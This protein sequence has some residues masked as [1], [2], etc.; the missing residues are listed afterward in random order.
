MDVWVDK[1]VAASDELVFTAGTHRDAIRMRYSDFAALVN[2]RV[3]QF[4]EMFSVAAA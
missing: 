3:G 1:S 2:P 4:A